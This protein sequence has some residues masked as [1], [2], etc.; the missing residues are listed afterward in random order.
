MKLLCSNIHEFQEFS[1]SQFPNDGAPKDLLETPTSSPRAM[2]NG[3]EEDDSRR[4]IGLDPLYN[5]A[6]LLSYL[7]L[8][9]VQL[10]EKGRKLIPEVL[11]R[12]TCFKRLFRGQPIFEEQMFRKIRAISP[13]HN[14]SYVG[15]KN[16]KVRS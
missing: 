7:D 6:D 5:N 12:E 14:V 4:L 1:H 10:D 9:G 8:P 16:A 11:N 13:T 2:K 15:L 3:F